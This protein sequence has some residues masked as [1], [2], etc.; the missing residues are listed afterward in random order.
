MYGSLKIEIPDEYKS[1][2]NFYVYGYNKNQEL[3]LLSCEKIDGELVISTDSLG[4]I[5]ILTEN[6]HWINCMFYITISALGAFVIGIGIYF[7]IK[8]IRKKKATA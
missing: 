4:K 3:K 2:E 8:R 7:V 5:V 1:M 6:E